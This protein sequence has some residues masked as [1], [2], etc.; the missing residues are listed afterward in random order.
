MSVTDMLFYSFSEGRVASSRAA[1]PAR[2][3]GLAFAAMSTGRMRPTWCRHM[4]SCTFDSMKSSV[5]LLGLLGLFKG[6]FSGQ[7]TS[8]GKDI[9]TPRDTRPENVTGLSCS[10][11]FISL[12]SH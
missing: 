6:R 3:S 5:S 10:W 9:S 4:R 12:P 1:E 8:A 11:I 2:A 7:V